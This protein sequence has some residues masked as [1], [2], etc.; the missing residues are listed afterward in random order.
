MT[1]KIIV[2]SLVPSGVYGDEKE[3]KNSKVNSL[4]NGN[5]EFRKNNGIK[6]FNSMNKNNY[7]YL[8][9]T[10]NTVFNNMGLH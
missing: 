8:G 4:N 7:I 2:A 10:N 3:N 9:S 6:F 1:N 5:N